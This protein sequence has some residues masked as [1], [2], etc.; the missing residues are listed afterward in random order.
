[1][2]S[3]SNSSDHKSSSRLSKELEQGQKIAEEAEAIWGYGSHAGIIRADR[4]AALHIQCGRINSSSLTLEVGCGTGGIS[5]RIAPTGAR[6][7]ATDL[8]TALINQAKT[9]SDFLNVFYQIA[10]AEVLP[11]SPNTFDVIVGNAILHHLD[12]SVALKEFYRVLKPKGRIVFT[13]PNM[14]NPQVALQKNWGW[15]KEKRGETPD[16]TAFFSWKIRRYLKNLGY[17]QISICPFDFLHPIL[18]K[19]L[20]PP[21]LKIEAVLER[22]PLVRQIAGSLLIVGCKPK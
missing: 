16:E 7:I 9:N 14:L 2:E 4:R 17:K 5:R 8:S 13:E 19:I 18:P 1:M 21:L 10:N 6:I 22:I 12:P 11:F 15:L 20:I 3:L